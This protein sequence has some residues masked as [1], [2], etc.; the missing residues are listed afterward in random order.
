MF[1]YNIIFFIVIYF[2][3]LFFYNILN[4]IFIKLFK[5]HKN[6]YILNQGKY[7]LNTGDF[8]LLKATIDDFIKDYTKL[9][10]LGVGN[11]LRGDD[12]LGPFI[13]NELEK[14]INDCENI[15]LINGGSAPEN[16]TGLIK[17]ENPSH[18]MIID[19]ALMDSKPG[20]IKFINKEHIANINASTHSMS[21]SFL[22]KYLEK[23]IDFKFLFVGIEPLTM[24]LGEDLSEEVLN[25]VESLKNA[26]LFV[27]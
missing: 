27:L 25:S 8:I 13:I 16:F 6:K 9:I 3:V 1:I 5:Y 23:D 21:L 14:D 20:T 4:Y 10:I 24:D 12:S 26:I 19:A 11:E 22:V 17:K 2:T 7:F 18:I 15:I